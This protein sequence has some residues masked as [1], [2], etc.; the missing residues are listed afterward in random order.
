MNH[1]F[2]ASRH[3]PLVATTWSATAAVEQIRDIVQKTLATFNGEQLWS[4]HP[5]LKEEFGFTK[6][7]VNLW[8]G[9][10]GT[11][12][13]LNRLAKYQPTASPFDFSPFLS[14]L[15]Q[16]HL[17]SIKQY[18]KQMMISADAVG[19]LLGKSGIWLL[20]WQ[21]TQDV[22]LLD[23]LANAIEQNIDNS[24]NELMWAAPG[25][26]LVALFLYRFTQ[27]TRWLRL[28]QRSADHLFATWQYHKDYD[29]QLWTQE[30]AGFRVPILGLVHGLAGNVGVLLQSQALLSVTQRQRLQAQALKAFVNTAELEANGANWPQVLG[31]AWPGADKG[32]LQLCHGVPGMLIAYAPLWTVMDSE[33]REIFLKAA[34][35]VWQAGP[36]KKP[37]GL[38]HGTAGNGYTF[39][40]C[41]TCT[42]DEKWLVRARKFA[43]HAIQQAQQMEQRYHTIRVD[44]W[45]G[46]IG[47]ALYLHDCLEGQS[48]FPLFDYF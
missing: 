18:P 43:M 47:L 9:A 41:F 29:C 14:Q 23:R 15:D 42:Q 17:N 5:D 4:V 10:A 20:Q 8:H 1:L 34:D 26:L 48:D 36:L 44:N 11:I 12:W 30:L 16:L 32:L 33:Q 46:D 38:C 19:Y 3:E 2:E 22:S 35:L 40:K 24:A 39:L 13:G 7:V 25:T 45:C 6:P 21:L 37:W 31:K 27:Q 28:V